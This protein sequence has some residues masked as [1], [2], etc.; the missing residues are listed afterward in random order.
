[1]DEVALFTHALPPNRR[2]ARRGQVVNGEISEAVDNQ[3]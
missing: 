2:L 1:V 3:A